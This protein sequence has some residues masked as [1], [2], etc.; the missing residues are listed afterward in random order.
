MLLGV[1]LALAAGTIVIYIVSQA[2][3]SGPTL[4]YVVESTM[5]LPA[6]S[7][8]VATLPT[9]SDPSQKYVLISQAF[10]QKQVPVDV[11]PADAFQWKSMDDLNAQLTNEVV[12]GDFLQGEILRTN[13]ERLAKAGTGGPGSFTNVNPAH[14]AIGQVLVMFTLNGPSGGTKPLAVQGDTV[15]FL[16]V[17]CNLPNRSG[18]VSQTTLQNMYVYAV[19]GP[20]LILAVSHDQ[21]LQLMELRQVTSE[22]D[23]AIRKPGDT[24]TYTT[25]SVDPASIVNDFHF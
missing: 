14:L 23:I 16:A 18:C 15:D 6:N 13:D 17:A 11:A 24:A 10:A 2:T 25:S 7:I 3:S 5:K 22:I 1:L 19:N 21:A 4:T 9:T 8:L 12:T 20:S